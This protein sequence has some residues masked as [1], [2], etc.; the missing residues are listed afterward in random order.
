MKNLFKNISLNHN[1]EALAFLCLTL[2]SLI[3]LIKFVNLTPQ[4]DEN[5]FFAENDPQFQNEL[6]ISERFLR[7][8]T[9][10]IISAKGDIR[11]E[12][13]YQ[14]IEAL[15]DTLLEAPG[16]SGIKSISEGPANIQDAINS[17]LWKRLL[18]AEDQQSTN[19]I[20]LLNDKQ[21]SQSINPIEKIIHAAEDKN[22]QLNISGLSYIVEL[23][24]RNL[25]HDLRTF[26]LLAFVV[27]A[28]AIFWIFR[29]G[30][31][32]LGTMISCLNAATLT[33]MI[34]S[35]INIPIGLLTANLTTIIFVLTL[36]HIV[37][38][39][40][41]W[42]RIVKQHTADDPDNIVEQA[43]N[44]TFLASFWSMLTTLLGFLSL[45][46]VPAKPLRELGFSGAVG[47]VIAIMVA[48]G[49]YPAFLK[50]IKPTSK[51]TEVHAE[52]QKKL[53][54]FL[55]A[56][57]KH[58][59]LAVLILLLISLPGLAFIKTDPSLPSFFSKNGEIYKGLKYIDQNGGSSP[60]MIVVKD[61]DQQ[62]LNSQQAYR[63]LWNLQRRLEE[64]P[65]VGSV[66]SLPVLLAQAKENPLANLIFVD[67]L[68]NI[69]EK[70]SYDKIS[71]SFISE[72]R[73]SSLFFLRMNEL[74]RKETRLQI[75]ERIKTMVKDEGFIP[76]IIGGIYSLQGHLSKLVGSSLIF[77]LAWLLLLFLVIAWII[78]RSWQI[79]IAMTLSVTI[80]PLCILGFIGTFGIPLDTISA[81]ASNVAIAM[82]I[83]S[84]IH[85]VKAYKRRK[86]N[87]KDTDDENIWEDIRDD[88]WKP[89]L[90]V[91]MIIVL[92]FSIFLFS[93]FPPTQRFGIAI[94]YGT[95][96]AALTS[97]YI[98]PMLIRFNFSS[99]KKYL[100]K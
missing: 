93:S 81:P 97:L 61:Q 46:T 71:R 35:L 1:K 47:T 33:F 85:M 70:P 86:Q 54:D 55:S 66:L 14:K 21:S 98:M 77:G 22:F 49:V 40:Y 59:R 84:M 31:I 8:D 34:T 82:G 23:I 53:Y 68:I 99:L 17:S 75:I 48:Y 20:V 28:L 100:R 11:S 91:M 80:I 96:L 16:V 43:V 27:F 42:Q 90:S 25:L 36:S 57:K 79:S 63:K 39:T 32:L 58:V 2:L 3:A 83:D 5:F 73:Q 4:V 52:L 30:I 88:M 89:I 95:I 15:S 13:Y 29:S 9:Q 56:Q 44:M 64:Y 87:K 50:M 67:W 10:L 74:N 26:S 62:I 18:I 92:G 76:E 69:L 45:L 24:K 60:L 78:S 6:K 19:I 12:Q 38:L 72:D 51:H 7:K 41:N 37:F 94:V 65:P